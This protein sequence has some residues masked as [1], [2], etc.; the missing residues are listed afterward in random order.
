MISTLANLVRYFKSA[1]A[2]IANAL[3][4]EIPKFMFIRI[5]IFM[6]LF[7]RAFLKL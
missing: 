7:R 2:E 1:E 3:A 6:F 4:L 5:K